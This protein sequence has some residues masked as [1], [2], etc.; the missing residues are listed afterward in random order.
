M[1]T[2][3]KYSCF[4]IYSF[5]YLM[6]QHPTVESFTGWDENTS[7]RYSLSICNR[8]TELERKKYMY[9]KLKSI[10][11]TTLCWLTLKMSVIGIALNV[12]QHLE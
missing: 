1:Q 11:S 12:V 6:L 7:F 2:F 9:Q 3:L 8:K 4:L 10:A 5:I